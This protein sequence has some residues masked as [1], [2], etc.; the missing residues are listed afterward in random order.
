MIRTRPH[1]LNDLLA[2][3][4][5]SK[6][7]LYVYRLVPLLQVTNTLSEADPENLHPGGGGNRSGAL[8]R[9]TAASQRGASRGYFPFQGGL[10]CN[11]WLAGLRAL[12]QLGHLPTTGATM[13]PLPPRVNPPLGSQFHKVFFNLKL[14]GLGERVSFILR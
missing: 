7:M 1:G 4:L 9:V 11:F 5:K 10:A 8:S 2:N 13:A 12:Y 14:L 3:C 6:T